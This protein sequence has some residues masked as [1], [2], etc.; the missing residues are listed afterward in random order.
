MSE[1][2][3]AQ[4]QGRDR[5]TFLE[6]MM[7]W[8]TGLIV[9]AMT[10]VAGAAHAQ[11]PMDALAMMQGVWSGPAHGVGYGGKAYDITQTERVGPMLDGQ[12]L[13]IEGR[14]Y[15]ADGSVAFNALGVIS[16]KA[17]TN[18]YE[19]RAY[20]GGR[21]VTAPLTV[22][23]KVASWEMPAGPNAVMRFT[24][25]FSAGTWHETGR[26]IVPGAAPVTT[27]DM[28][29]TRRGDTDWPAAGAVTP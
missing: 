8:K 3:K 27:L 18:G 2:F 5:L 25:D 16:W 6:D 11:Q 14:G 12:V 29:L 22:D 13:V 7:M 21:A 15:E 1:T 17:E 26:Y 10:T 19:F 20:N 23:G 9:A 28:T 4:R 24:M